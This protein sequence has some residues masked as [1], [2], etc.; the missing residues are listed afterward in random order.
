MVPTSEGGGEHKDGGTGGVEVGEQ[1]IDDLK[2]VA[3]V[4]EDIG[5]AG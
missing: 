4:N 3:G 2:F 5:F 1:V